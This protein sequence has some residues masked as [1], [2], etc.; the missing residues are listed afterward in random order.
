MKIKSSFL[1][2]ENRFGK[3]IDNHFWEMCLFAIVMCVIFDYCF[4]SDRLPKDWLGKADDL[5][6]IVNIFIAI[7]AMI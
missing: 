6:E 4:A 7:H 2:Y 5:K 3:F 1:Y